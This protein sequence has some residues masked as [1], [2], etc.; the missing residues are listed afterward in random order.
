MAWQ[1]IWCNMRG[2]TLN[3]KFQLL[4]IYR[5]GNWPN[6]KNI[7]IFSW[8]WIYSRCLSNLKQSFVHL[9]FN[10]F[11]FD[12]LWCSRCLRELFDLSQILVE[13]QADSKYT[14]NLI[15]FTISSFVILQPQTILWTF[16]NLLVW[17]VP[18]KFFKKKWNTHQI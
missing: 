8:R 18:R 12:T 16:Y 1:L 5:G 10:L 2:A 7:G 9:F 17:K 11:L 6:L 3:T 14:K 15:L 13:C 4:V